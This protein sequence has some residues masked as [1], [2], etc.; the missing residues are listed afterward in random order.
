MQVPATQRQV[1]RFGPFVV[2]LASREL[3]NH[4]RKVNLQEKPFQ[5]L[6]VLLDQPGQLVTREQ[7]RER[8]WPADTFVDFEHSINTAVKKVREALE[9]D[10]EEPH[11]I[12]TLPK[13]GYRFIASVSEPPVE[14]EGA[15]PQTQNGGSMW[16]EMPHR[17]LCNRWYVV[18]LGA[19]LLIG[20]MVAVQNLGLLQRLWR[21]PTSQ[22]VAS[23]AIK[24][25]AV[26]P[27]QNLS[28]N[29][30]EEYFADGLTDA[31]ITDLGRVAGLR[32][33]SRT[34]AMT[35]KETSKSLPQIAREL[36]VDAIVEGT[37]LRSGNRLRVTVQLIR[38]SPEEHLWAE[39]YEHGTDEVI[40]LEQRLALAIAH[41]GTGRLITEEQAGATIKQTSNPKAYDAYLRGRY[42]WNE[43]SVK[44]ASE[45]A[46]YFEQ[47][48]R[49][50]PSFA[51]AYSGLA[52][53]YAVGWGPWIDLPRAESY[54]RNALALE[55]NLAEAH[56][57]LGIA[58]LY[59]RKFDEAEKELKRA[60]EL[61]P[62]YAMA[63]H[64][65]AMH[66]VAMGRLNEALAENDRA[67]R[68]DPFSFPVNFFRGGI[69]MG[70]HEYDQAIEQWE[71][72]AAINPQARGMH[73]ILARVYWI[74]GK[75]INALAEEREDANLAKDP[76]R[77]RELEKIVGVYATAGLHAAL[78][79][80]ARNKE[81][82]CALDVIEALPSC[83]EYAVARQYGVLG[84]KD[85]L[86]YW[87]KRG[88][89]SRTGHRNAMLV[90][91][92]KTAPEFD[93]VRSDPRFRS[94]LHSIGLDD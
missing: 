86:L 70:M 75:G 82:V 29:A 32:V 12:E 37:V 94:L 56:A 30:D 48:L 87:L 23:G 53:Y 6:A 7:F 11:F 65:Y 38:A 5:V 89:A 64:W 83:D 84:E 33:I 4:G 79:Q 85:K 40:R 77:L 34:S 49:E 46:A 25:V 17:W 59:Q 68:L 27:L 28:R 51:L 92:L 14:D 9:D 3:R 24:S 39:R 93:C 55:P 42:L 21:D 50:D 15:W 13:R 81:R 67:R 71:T 66:H 45:A 16:P 78:L 52:D 73:D 19:I 61:N 62:N 43:R 47:A 63:H 88:V 80:S 54:A 58:N 1:I 74:Q 91:S 22:R 35:Y 72:A 26:L 20:V 36:N 76:A 41:E 44:P 57:S 8:L 60:I 31:L 10:A 69:L 2:D 18:L 90:I